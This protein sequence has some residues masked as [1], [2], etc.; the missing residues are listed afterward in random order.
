MKKFLN[1]LCAVFLPLGLIGQI[2]FTD[3]SAQLFHQ[4]IRSGAPIGIADMDADGLD[5]IVRLHTG[6]S[7]VIDYQRPN[8]VFQGYTYGQLVGGQWS[9][10]IADVDG[11]GYNDIFTG[12][13]YDGLKLLKANP[14]GNG[15]SLNT[16]SFSNIFLQGS[17]FV[18][19]DGDMDLDIFACHD[20]GLSQPYENTGNGNMQFNPS[21]ISAVSTV[22][23]DN[24]GNYGS[25]W[26]DYDNDKDL[27]LYISKCRLG[28]TDPNDG[29]RLNLLFQNDGTGHYTEVAAQVGLQPHGQSWATDF[30]DIDNDGDLDAIVVNHDIPNVLY[31][32]EGNGV[33]TDITAGSGI[34]V[35]DG[36]GIQ[37]KFV[38]FD[39]DGFIDILIGGNTSNYKILRNNGNSTFSGLLN[40]FPGSGSIHSF[41]TGDL[42]ND[43][44]I[45]VLASF[46]SGYNTPSSTISDRLYLNGGN[47]NH[48]IKLNLDGVVS[49]EN[50]IGS[51]V[52]LYGAW[53]KQIREVRSGE[54]Y[55]ISTSHLVHFG[56]GQNVTVD[57]VVVMWP[58]GAESHII[59]PGIN[60]TLDV[61]EGSNC[62]LSIDFLYDVNDLSVGFQEAST[63]G[64]TSWLWTFGD[65]TSS[66][67]ANPT[68]VYSEPGFYTV[69]LNVIGI[70]GSG[71]IIRTVNVSCI[72]PTPEFGITNL[73][74]VVASFEDLST[75]LPNSWM[76]NFGDGSAP[77]FDQNPT[78]T[79]PSEGYYTIC[80][81][82]EN[83]CGFGQIC[84]STLI[85]CL[86][87]VPQFISSTSQL[88]AFF[89]ST[90]S[91]DVFAWSWDFGDG[92]TSDMENPNHTYAEAGTYQVC[93]EVTGACG[94][95]TV[96][97]SIQI[98]CPPPTVNFSTNVTNRTVTV[99]PII[100]GGANS[101]LWDFGDGATANTNAPT[102][103]YEE[104][105]T[106]QIC[107]TATNNCGP[108]TLCQTVV[109]DCNMPEADFEI[110]SVDGF[111]VTVH[112][113]SS[114]N[115]TAWRWDFGDMT[116]NFSYDQNPTYTY[117][118]EG[119]YSICMMATNECGTTA[120]C[121][122][123][124][125]G[126]NP[127]QAA[128]TSQSNELS[129][130]FTDTSTESPTSWAWDFG[131][132]TTSIEQ[133]PNHVYA[134]PGQYN[135]CLVITN[136]CG[137]SQVCNTVNVSC[138]APEA[139]F[140]TQSNELVF[141]FFDNS[142]PAATS[143]LW[144]FGDGQ[145]ANVQTPIHAYASSGFYN[146]CLTASS[147]CGTSTICQQIV[148]S[149]P[150][151]VT[152]FN[153]NVSGLT[154][155]LTDI[156]T[157][158]PI[159][160][161][162]SFGDGETS[163]TQ[164]A[165]HTFA[166]PGSY[167]ICLEAI[168][169]CG[170]NTV[171]QTVTVNCATPIAAFSIQSNDLGVNFIDQSINGPT[172]W[173]WDFGDGTT[174]T[175]ANPLHIYDAP[176]SYMVCLT[177]SSVC[178]TNQMCT[179]IQVDCPAPMPSFVYEVEDLAVSFTGLV[180]ESVDTW[181]WDFGDGTTSTEQNPVHDFAVPG[182]YNICVSI[183][184]IC[185]SN[186]FCQ[187][188]TVSCTAPIAGFIFSI[189]GLNVSYFD[190]SN[191]AISN[192]VW[193]FGDGGTF[194]GQ[195]PNY[196]YSSP[197]TYQ[198]CLEVSGI[199]GSDMICQQITVDCAAPVSLFAYTTNG[200]MVDFEDESSGGP[201]SWNWDFGDGNVSNEENPSYEYSAAGTYPVCLTVA[202][203]CGSNTSC[204]NV[205]VECE[206]PESQFSYSTTNLTVIFTDLSAGSP[207]SWTWT[208]GDG[209]VSTD[210]NPTHH[211][212]QD[213]TY[214]VC[215]TTEN[216][217]GAGT[218]ECRTMTIDCE[219]PVAQ[220][221]VNG[222]GHSLNFQNTSTGLPTTWLWDFGDGETSSDF[223]PNHTFAVAN[224]Y[225]V[226]LTVTNDCGE[227]S[228]C[229]L[230]LII[231][232][233]DTPESINSWEVMP[234]PV[235][236]ILYIKIE[237]ELVQQGEIR[238]FAHNGQLL[239]T[240]TQ[241]FVLGN[242][243]IQW[244][245]EDLPSGLYFVQLKLED[246]VVIKRIVVE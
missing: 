142:S 107:L 134:Q 26:I 227:S 66:T 229:Q 231:D 64:A 230:I 165:N 99:T 119:E 82:A 190:Q 72:P 156:S 177:V 55:G 149:C 236:E 116:M 200:M 238:L 58:S 168:N 171:C 240:Q 60:Q 124:D 204:Q 215:L 128:F 85:G 199:C 65:G 194:N 20:D 182:T 211:Y 62:F 167:T 232:G 217:C 28:V 213:G 79:F 8:G 18:D 16:I 130:N 81:L 10:S 126:C 112:D 38:D 104:N 235:S 209:V 145:V 88:Q 75:N 212:A 120:F 147:I 185:G 208:F 192:W 139:N 63:L 54:S 61:T 86:Q 181:S 186:Q 25:V 172:S 11:N 68:H 100:G 31:R 159:E 30:G 40:V 114:N 210:Q 47:G 49:N 152:G 166:A 187:Q 78:H 201:S 158:A 15:F 52:E 53:G 89:T 37:V 246:G 6:N 121:A 48:Y 91:S 109:I 234:N 21:L 117:A 102:H 103:Q 191:G 96:C 160:W 228:D 221:A 169:Q 239:R 226:C 206:L 176:G 84:R 108:T 207:S 33:F 42:N 179:Q 95:E 135:A 148:A 76:W 154:V 5:D 196:S 35:A 183:S 110:V 70:C 242:N 143:W 3:Q 184:N 197:G 127:P 1:F 7:L 17:N 224:S 133:H 138:A 115:P 137:N 14:A 105:G 32:N 51:R 245:V 19:I 83:N 56:L 4:T 129:V 189:D 222:T 170:A 80:L 46:G 90:S 67:E 9:I 225:T 132:G 125:I 123:V 106:Y 59:A 193:T 219:L 174:S 69:T 131:D 157:N 146:V 223:S 162:W 161:N 13:A 198:V 153:L 122:F 237:N 113:L 29:R 136:A 118:V 12:G 71:Q 27:D 188:V 98:N 45:D 205:V 50:G 203:V 180:G 163:T 92:A 97:H 220:F 150:E 216:E 144:S 23:S 218:T 57:S 74:G 36:G 41:S 44:F 73:D 93:L 178:G 22:P 244:S 241:N 195:S 243:S 43:G 39:N 87:T 2:S 111:T 233:I 77:S 173:L 214:T 155:S 34:S 164:N 202:S 94:N 24:S 141:Q 140:S 101:L 175:D 151:P